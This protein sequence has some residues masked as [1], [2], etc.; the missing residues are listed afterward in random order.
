MRYTKVYV[1]ITARNV[2]F[3]KRT[4][5]FLKGLQDRAANPGVKK[6]I[7][8]NL[9]NWLIN[10]FEDVEQIRRYKA[11]D[12]DWLKT[13]LERGD[14]VYSL[15]LSYKDMETISH[16]L[17]YLNTVEGDVS[18]IS[19]PQLQKKVK[20]WEESFAKQKANEEDGIELVHSYS[21]GFSWV[22]V[23]GKNS[24]NREGKLINHCVGSYYNQVK[25]GSVSIYSLR[26]KSN[27]P[28]C[29]IELK[30][31]EIQQIKGNSNEAVKEQYRKYVI[32]F[33][34]KKYVKFKSVIPEELL[35]I[36]LI[37][38]DNKIYDIDHIPNGLVVK[39]DINLYAAKLKSL[40]ENLKVGGNL[41][42][43]YSTLTSLPRGLKV[44]GDLNLGYSE[45]TSLPED[46]QV[47]SLKLAGTNISELPKGLKVK[48]NLKLY[49][50]NITQLPKD[51]EVGGDLDLRYGRITS[52]PDGLK[53]KGI[54]RVNHSKLTSLPKNLEIGGLDF[55]YSKITSLPEG[56]KI[57]GDLSLYHKKIDSL[58]DNL[59]IGGDLV[60]SG[61]NVTQLPKGL[62][63]GGTLDL[64]GAKVVSLP[65]D[66]K[67]GNLDASYS[68]LKYLPENFKIKGYLNIS[69]TRITSLPNGLEVGDDLYMQD[70][71]ITQLPKD[72]K[73][74]GEIVR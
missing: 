51:L 53:V 73:V 35:N 39:G 41:N 38:I 3:S 57:N 69:G 70:S 45:V 65:D 68:L 56:L 42:L 60:L 52:L 72:L 61:S 46:L 22:N 64:Y 66:I 32:D 18:R 47:Y 67:I 74:G 49:D 23:F 10:S 9:R 63:V 55:G 15:H 48:G 50:L 16:W 58:P 5:D 4:E 20:E 29:T 40:P 37:Q 2:L 43:S 7:K 71:E 19:I 14:E 17:D 6:Y 8:S 30:H 1:T 44:D 12:P 13:A 26:D 11:G 62:K 36:N 25:N 28:H 21:D 34:K 27:K 24:L 54:L 31:G 59:E 33:L